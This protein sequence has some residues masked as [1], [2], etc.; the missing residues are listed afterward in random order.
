MATLIKFLTACFVAITGDDITHASIITAKKNSQTKYFSRQ[1]QL[2]LACLALACILTGNEQCVKVCFNMERRFSG[3]LIN[4]VNRSIN[5][6]RRS[7][8]CS[9]AFEAV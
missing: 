7:N 3:F 4:P 5:I 1:A 6:N 9:K 2:S 8:G